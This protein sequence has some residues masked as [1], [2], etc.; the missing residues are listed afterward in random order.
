M[1]YSVLFIILMVSTQAQAQIVHS[2]IKTSARKNTI[3]LLDAR[4]ENVWQLNLMSIP[5]IVEEGFGNIEEVKLR[6]KNLK[7]TTIV[8]PVT[9]SNKTAGASPI[10]GASFIGTQLKAWTP[11]DN[12]IAIS[13]D[14][15]IVSAINE[16]M[17]VY[18]RNGNAIVTGINWNTFLNN[19]PA[20]NLGKY[21]PKVLY[22]PYHD[23]FII[24]I[25]HAPGTVSR[26]KIVFAFS[27]TNNPTQG[28]YI[29]DLD[30]NPFANNAW[31]DYPN[32]A[33][34]EHELFINCNLFEAAPTYNYK[35]TYIQQIDLDSV[36]AGGNMQFMTWSG[37]NENKYITLVPA[38]EG[39]GNAVDNKMDFVMMNPGQGAELYRFTI[40]DTMN[41]PGLSLDSAEYPIAAFTA[42]ADAYIKDIPSGKIDSISTGSAWIHNAFKLDDKILFT[43]AANVGGWCGV[44]LGELDLTAG[45]ADYVSYSQ[46]GTDMAYPAIASIGYDNKDKNV[47][48]VFVRA[49]TNTLPE[50][51]LISIDNAKQWST[52]QTIKTGDTIV[53]I[54]GGQA[55]RW[56][57]YS[58]ISRKYNEPIPEAW[59]FGCYST[60][61]LPRRASYGN[62]IAQVITGDMPVSVENVEAKEKQEIAVYPNPVIDI[63]TID[64]ELE[65]ESAVRIHL[66]D[67]SGRK[68]K[69]LFNDRLPASRNR[70]SFN[71]KALPNGQYFVEVNVAG[72]RVVKQVV[73]V[74]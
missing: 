66:Y 70:F 51:D 56:G 48:M 30:G 7:R 50:V 55:E 36:Y 73:L 11:S 28:W 32:M 26:S 69:E 27:A 41:A 20:Y 34:N 10:V 39:Q 12:T 47:A 54:I 37:F 13:N 42:C 43:F 68:V 57:D 9:T 33:V 53:D 3:N 22:D 61:T 6:N 21:D 17:E 71:R 67:V 23:R 25:L 49:D 24:C 18:D 16:G 19:D 60:N 31:T 63:Y 72:E 58:D 1:K 40:T 15:W 14:G 62:W 38:P 44:H 4:E 8:P 59:L 65:K 2:T 35:G 29:Y 46:A 45:T 5:N 52:R 64:F 74:K